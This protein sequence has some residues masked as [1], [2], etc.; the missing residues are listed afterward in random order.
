[1]TSVTAGRAFDLT[2]RILARCALCLF[3][4]AFYH[5]AIGIG[6]LNKKSDDL[7]KLKKLMKKRTKVCFQVAYLKRHATPKSRRLDGNSGIITLI[8]VLQILQYALLSIQDGR[9]MSF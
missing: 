3:R 9:Y 4:R 7:V 6:M 1:M 8:R 5:V 2:D